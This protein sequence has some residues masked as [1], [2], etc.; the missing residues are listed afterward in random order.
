MNNIRYKRD[1]DLI[2]ILYLKNKNQKSQF[3]V[4]RFYFE[5]QNF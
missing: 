2:N 1:T 5:V 4:E 3:F